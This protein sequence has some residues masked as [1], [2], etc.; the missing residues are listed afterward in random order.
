MMPGT[1]DRE[2]V[3][4]RVMRVLSRGPA[5]APR[6][7]AP[8]IYGSAAIARIARSLPPLERAYANIRF[9]ILRPK[10]LSV[11]DLLLPDE[12]R[13]L[14]IGCGFGLFSAYFGQTQPGRKILGV[15]PDERR[16]AMAR[17][18]CKSLGL[19]DHTFLA[20]DARDVRIEG[21]F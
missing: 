20:G 14:D 3:S 11:M 21:T 15:D 13:I 2:P 12:G 1:S 8:E 17:S 10:L 4:T 6:F 19:S 18:V 7:D 9:S 16:I 5:P